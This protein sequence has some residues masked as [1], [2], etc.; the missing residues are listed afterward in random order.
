MAESL[1]G[2]EETIRVDDASTSP[3]PMF[4]V[5]GR[6]QPEMVRVDDP[7]VRPIFFGH[8]TTGW[9]GDHRL[10]VFSWPAKA[11]FVLVRLCPDG[12]Y[13][14]IREVGIPDGRPLSPASI[15]AVCRWLVATDARRGYNV[16]DAVEAHNAAIDRENERREAEWSAAQA[17]KLA[18]AIKRDLGT[19]LG[20]R[21]F[22]HAI[23]EVPWHEE[24]ATEGAS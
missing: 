15:N 24:K 1:L 11:V 7:V 5:L 14:W 8:P 21:H 9:E 19:H 3:H 10:A 20:G 16:A 18:W 6:G 4:L 13:R 22:D 23:G 2:R 17:D 12:E